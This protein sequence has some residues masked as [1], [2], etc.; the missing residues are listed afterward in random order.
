MVNT[1]ALVIRIGGVDEGVILGVHGL[2]FLLLLVFLFLLDFLLLDFGMLLRQILNLACIN[3]S[4]ETL[5]FG[6]VFLF[7]LVFLFLFDLLI[8]VLSSLRNKI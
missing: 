7:L 6:F 4:V 2:V 8:D 3:E 5:D 1:L